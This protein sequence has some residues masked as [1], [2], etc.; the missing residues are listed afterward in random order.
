MQITNKILDYKFDELPDKQ[1]NLT[2]WL[3][4]KRKIDITL[5]RNDAKN[6]RDILK[7]IVKAG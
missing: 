4:D 3:E 2:M 1:I 5:S 7:S 6:W